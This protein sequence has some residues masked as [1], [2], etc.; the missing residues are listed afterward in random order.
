MGD[1]IKYANDKLTGKVVILANSDVYFDKTLLNLVIQAEEL[2]SKKAYI[3]SRRRT[4]RKIYGEFVEWD[5][6][7]D[8][9][10]CEYYNGSHDAFVFVPPLPDDLVEALPFHLGVP[11]VENIVIWEMKHRNIKVLNPC[12]VINVFHL[13]LKREPWKVFKRVD[14]GK[15]GISLPTFQL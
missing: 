11:G 8:R 12:R 5:D 6:S 2:D 4:I 13:H 15:V 3:I 14:K 9:D 1:A 10:Q 7:N